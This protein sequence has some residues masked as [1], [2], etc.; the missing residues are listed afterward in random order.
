MASLL[1][2]PKKIID[3]MYAT[4]PHVAKLLDALEADYRLR[5]VRAW[6]QFKAHLRPIRAVFADQR[7]IEVTEEAVDSY[8]ENRLAEGKAPAT[9]NRETQLLGQAFRTKM[10]KRL[11][12]SGPD[13]RHLSERDNSRQGY[14]EVGEFQAL[15]PALPEDLQDF[16]RFG[17]L[18]G[19]RKGEIAS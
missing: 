14:F 2:T 12:L 15:V 5:K 11:N 10:A 1:R 6:T 4:S 7:V 16:T 18:S 9:V 19:W 8:I 17:Y 3:G 13:I